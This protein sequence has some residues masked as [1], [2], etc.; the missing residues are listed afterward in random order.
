MNDWRR[1]IEDALSAFITVSQLAGEPVRRDELELEFLPAPH[2]QPSS[3]PHG[4]MA[5]YAFWWNGEWLKIGKAGPKTAARYVS[6][7]Y[8]QNSSNSNLAKSLA[9]D[10]QMEN[11]IG[12]D[13]NYPGDWIRKS[14]C[15]ANIL[16]SAQK[17]K[18]LLA[19][20]E[21]FLH[22]RL[23]PRYEG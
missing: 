1:E 17:S 23:K 12:F 6:Q 22:V 20:L 15:R 14:T 21:A 19:L 16:I 4:K 18:E 13:R 8:N 2:R 10:L 11:A 9:H 3:L 5:I 7:H